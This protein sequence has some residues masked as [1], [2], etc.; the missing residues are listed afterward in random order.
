MINSHLNWTA[1]YFDAIYIFHDS[2]NFGHKVYGGVGFGLSKDGFARVL[3]I[4]KSQ[5][6]CKSDQ[7]D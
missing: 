4:F 3:P 6:L 7:H 5:H 1:L 2:I